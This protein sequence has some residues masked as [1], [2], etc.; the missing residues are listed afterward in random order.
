LAAHGRALEN[1]A[2]TGEWWWRHVRSAGRF[3]AAD[4]A[5]KTAVFLALVYAARQLG[6][7]AF[8]EFALVYTAAQLTTLLADMGLT[9]LVLRQGAR[10]GRVQSASFWTAIAL[11]VAASV[12]C[13]LALIA[14]F[15]VLHGTGTATAAIY[16]PTLVLLT[17]TTSLESAAVAA[18]RPVRVAVSRLAGNACVLGLTI[19]LLQVN[20]T[21][22]VVAF[23][24]LGGAVVKLVFIGS[25]TRSFV[26][27]VA[28]RP[29]LI[30]PLLRKGS[31][32][33]GSAI[34]AFLYQRVDVLV[35]GSLAGVAA[36]G[37]YV[38]AYRILDG[39]LLLPA[40][41]VAA[42]L[43]S[44]A[45]RRAA[46]GAAG[47]GGGM[48]VLLLVCIGV[49]AAF[50]LVLARQFVVDLLYGDSYASSALI[51]GVLALSVPIF[52]ADIALVWL[53]YVQGHEK[54]VA[55]LGVVAFLANISINIA[56]IREFGGLGAA[57]ATVVTEAVISLGYAFTLGIHRY[58]RRARVLELLA[59]TGAYTVA[60]LALVMVCA[61]AGVH[62]ALTCLAV[63]GLGIALLA[64][65]YR[66]EASRVAPSSDRR[67]SA[68]SIV[69]NLADQEC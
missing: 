34:A 8:G 55:A 44:W 15:A 49:L 21:P 13:A 16:G 46:K 38:A 58:E 10:S 25:T 41:V 35:L 61:V 12:V 40:A 63:G 9:S 4:A 22:E 17:V 11:N 18:R 1:S 2:V 43:P 29:R 62:W 57:V 60:L 54:R 26:P 14:A 33:Y 36:A 66:R 42:F 20:E 24:F 39:V 48:V 50:E 47:R 37:E 6:P 5:A 7:A 30:A 19:G 59:T 32:F 51:L 65:V 23:A 45:E 28:V 3:S 27:S 56:L 53:A 68:A 64:M 67:P 52:Y 69:S 31:P